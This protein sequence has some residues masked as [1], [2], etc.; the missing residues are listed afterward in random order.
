M[1]PFLEALELPVPRRTIPHRPAYAMACAAEIV[2]P[3][4]N[5]NRFAVVQTCVDHTFRDD[6]AARE[7]GYRSI[8]SRQ[9][10]FQRSLAWLRNG[11]FSSPAGQRRR[12]RCAGPHGDRQLIE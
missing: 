6:K 9:D 12:A 5:F 4:S 11:A 7:L 8:I 1:E 2:A 3:Y 10:A